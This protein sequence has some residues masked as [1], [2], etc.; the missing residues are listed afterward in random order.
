MISSLFCFER[1][2][3]LNQ[4]KFTLRTLIYFNLFLFQV[5][6]YCGY[7]RPILCCV[8]G[9]GRWRRD[10]IVL[11]G[12]EVNLHLDNH[13]VLEI[14]LAL[15]P[16]EQALRSILGSPPSPCHFGSKSCQLPLGRRI[17][18]S[19]RKDSGNVKFSIDAASHGQVICRQSSV[20]CCQNSFESPLW[21]CCPSRMHLAVFS[22]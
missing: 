16:M 17:G 20:T 7:H 19:A 2:P 13:L 14:T 9:Y 22:F 3:E 11:M 18:K 1:N 8:V 4:S 21:S 10:W 12:F 15:R 6:C 5:I